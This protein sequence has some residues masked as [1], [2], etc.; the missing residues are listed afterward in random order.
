VKVCTFPPISMITFTHIFQI[1]TNAW[2]IMEGA[3]MTVL[4]QLGHMSA[5]VG[6]VIFYLMIPGHV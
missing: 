2:T 3:I 5:V 6:K 4:I 1:L